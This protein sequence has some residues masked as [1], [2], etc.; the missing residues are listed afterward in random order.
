MKIDIINQDF[1]KLPF[2]ES[3]L[4]R[5]KYGTKIQR[6]RKNYSRGEY[7]KVEDY[8]PWDIV[9]RV[10]KYFIGKSF[11]EAFSYY[12]KKVP[13]YQQKYFLEEFEKARPKYYNYNKYY[14]DNVG[15]IQYNPNRWN[16]NKTIS[17][18]S[19]DYQTELR[20]KVTGHKEIDFN[21]VCLTIF[22][23]FTLTNGI[24]RKYKERIPT[25]N[26]KHKTGYIATKKDFIPVIIK[27]WRKYF[28]SRNDPNYQK[29]YQEQVKAKKK[30]KRDKIK[31]S[32]DWDS[33]MK[34]G[35][36]KILDFK[37]KQ[38]AEIKRQ[39]ELNTQ[40]IVRHG[41]DPVTSFRTFRA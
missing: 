33:L 21:Q 19:D 11:D 16:R 18:S 14:I 20:H 41:F 37:K 7:H 22:K 6:W 3:I 9:N 34:D 1:D 28:T 27:G 31:Q 29:L 13:K 12:C 36:I 15:N 35:T 24:I 17:I 30:T 38:Q 2:R 39:E 4:N 32:K 40:C 23:E 25:S 10:I 8:Y 26:L 5:V